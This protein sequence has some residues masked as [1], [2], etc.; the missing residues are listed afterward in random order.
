MPL[1]VFE[2]CIKNSGVMWV[3]AI[4]IELC[5]FS[6]KNINENDKIFKVMGGALGIPFLFRVLWDSHIKMVF[7]NAIETKHA[8]SIEYWSKA[9]NEKRKKIYKILHEYFGTEHYL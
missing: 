1:L 2:V 8:M 6:C 9:F 3:F 5:Y 4:F 7:D